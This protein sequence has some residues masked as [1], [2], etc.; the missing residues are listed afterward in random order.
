[1]VKVEEITPGGRFPGGTASAASLA[2]LSPG[3]SA[4]AIPP[5]VAAFRS[6]FYE[7]QNNKKDLTL[8][9]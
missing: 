3:S 6:F 7:S 5:G 1:M 2:A 9:S 8:N 4:R